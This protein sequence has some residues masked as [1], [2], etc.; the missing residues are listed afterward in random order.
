MAKKTYKISKDNYTV[1]SDCPFPD[2][3]TETEIT[4]KDIDDMLSGIPFMGPQ[5]DEERVADILNSEKEFAL[6]RELTDAEE[7]IKEL[8]ERHGWQL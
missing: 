4:D 1:L 2:G 6:T 7:Y 3:T 5:T 8:K